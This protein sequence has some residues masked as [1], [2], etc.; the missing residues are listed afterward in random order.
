M[1]LW[2]A[3]NLCGITPHRSTAGSAVVVIP[4]IGTETPVLM[5]TIEI[6]VAAVV[7]SLWPESS[8]LAGFIKRMK[9][10]VN[11]DPPPV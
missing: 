7:E 1:R 2:P 9:D 10:D 6:P 8:N 4:R 5:A 11:P 3:W